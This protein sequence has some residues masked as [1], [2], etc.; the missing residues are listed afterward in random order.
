M[1]AG[2]KAAVSIGLLAA[3]F[4]LLPWA[5][6]RA[7][8]ASVPPALWLGALALFLIGH[9]VGVVKWRTLVHASRGRLR[10]R[11]ATR[12]YAAGLFANLCLPTIVGGDLLR[13]VLAG[14]A[15]GRM[16]AAFLAGVADRALDIATM[17]VLIT[18]G[19]LAARGALPGWSGEVLTAGVLLG[20]LGTL[21]AAPFVLRRPLARWPRRIRRPLGRGLVALRHLARHPGHAALALGLSLAIQS[22][23]VFINVWIGR[24]VGITLPLGVWFVAW[25]LAKIA[26]LMPISLGGLA[27][28]DATFGALLLPLGIPMAQG[29]VAALV[30]QTVMIGGGLTGGLVWWLLSRRAPGVHGFRGLLSAG[31]HG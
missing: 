10:L 8:A 19:A 21:A 11:D 2:A 25:P 29:V 7:A 20:A 15:T 13:A 27:V 17:A 9:Q 24:A 28:R 6:V 30:W 18:A 12:F 3:L 23:F 5:D 26:G 14:R 22:G 16:E 1:N 31:A 4:V